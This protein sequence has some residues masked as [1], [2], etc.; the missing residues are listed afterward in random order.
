VA[1]VKPASGRRSPQTGSQGTASW[2]LVLRTATPATRA[3]PFARV[4]ISR[5]L[6]E[7]YPRVAHI[8]EPVRTPPP[9]PG[10]MKSWACC[11]GFAMPHP[12]RFVAQR[13]ALPA[14]NG[15]DRKAQGNALG[16]DDELYE[17]ALKGRDRICCAPSGHFRR[18]RISRVPSPVPR[19]LPG[20]F[21]FGPF[22]ARN[23][24]ARAQEN[25][26]EPWTRPRPTFHQPTP[27]AS[28]QGGESEGTPA[29]GNAPVRVRD[30]T[31]TPIRRP[32]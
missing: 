31:H 15:P 32:N 23:A 18:K 28:S 6:T 1:G 8:P 14:L 29:A 7:V 9:T 3:R 17:S 11:L 27:T 30:P 22:R 19:A 2:G 10:L 24:E 20:A 25:R 21:L 5:F 26:R 16:I 12:A 13:C 4:I